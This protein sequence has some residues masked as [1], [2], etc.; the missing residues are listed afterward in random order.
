MPTI[1]PAKIAAAGFTAAA[2]IAAKIADVN[3]RTVRVVV[4]LIPEEG[5]QWT[6]I[7]SLPEG[8]TE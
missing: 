7:T 3:R 2:K 5:G 4:A 8:G 1:P 6:H